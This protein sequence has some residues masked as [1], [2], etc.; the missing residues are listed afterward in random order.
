MTLTRIVAA[1]EKTYGRVVPHVTDPFDMI[2]MENVAYLV[3]DERRHET[4][5]RLRRAIGITPDAIL[6]HSAG[7]I[8]V[9]RIAISSRPAFCS[10]S[11]K[12]HTAL[13]M[14]LLLHV[15]GNS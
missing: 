2:V 11:R 5:E 13:A 1:L 8:A 15:N 12:P 7:K 6:K 10:P 14:S 4:F 3:D 9:D